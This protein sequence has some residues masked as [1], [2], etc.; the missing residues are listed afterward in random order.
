[1]ACTGINLKLIMAV[2]I[3][4][5]KYLFVLKIKKKRDFFLPFLIFSPTYSIVDVLMFCTWL[6]KS[7]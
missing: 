5:W 3:L 7:T 4:F 1:M 6:G 2:F